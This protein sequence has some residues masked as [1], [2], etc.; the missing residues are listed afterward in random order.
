MTISKQIRWTAARKREL[1]AQIRGGAVTTEAALAAYTDLTAEEL[2]TWMDAYER[3]RGALEGMS[4]KA[5]H[6]G[7]KTQ[8]A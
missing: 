1:V 7:R 2:E 8:A 3:S 5:I 6:A 4:Q